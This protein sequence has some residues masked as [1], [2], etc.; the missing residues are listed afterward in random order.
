MHGVQQRYVGANLNFVLLFYKTPR[1]VNNKN[2]SG[3]I[4][5]EL[6]KVPLPNG[7]TL[8]YREREGG[9]RNLL[10]IHGNMTSSKHWDLLIDRLNPNL[11]VYALDSTRLWWLYL[12]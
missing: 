6:K 8:T 4:K 9:D 3:V 11:K 1:L 2:T 7:E 5:V 12:S 10:L